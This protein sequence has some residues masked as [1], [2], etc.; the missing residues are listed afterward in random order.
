MTE[1]EKCLMPTAMI[2]SDNRVLQEKTRSLIENQSDAI[3][4]AKTLFYF[5]RDQVKYS[6]YTPLFPLRASATF[7]RGDG[8]C[9]QKAILLAAMARVAHIPSRVG[10]ATIRNYLAPEKLLSIQ[11]SDLFV[12]HGFTEIYLNGEWIKAT[13]TFDLKTCAD[14]GFIPVEFNGTHHATLY[15]RNQSGDQHIE[16]VE[17]HGSYAD[18]PV[19]DIV[20]STITAYG[21]P[22][23][24]LWMSGLG[25]AMER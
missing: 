24:D 11:G 6:I 1:L 10:F 7:E 8:F 17:Q 23:L 5:V 25:L 19:D 13:P 22:Y 14:N 16:Y 15:P 2:D 4:K 3:E 18:V 21:K 12:R 20:E 9:I